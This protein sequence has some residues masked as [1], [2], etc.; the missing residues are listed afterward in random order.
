MKILSSKRLFA[1]IAGFLSVSGGVSASVFNNPLH[2]VEGLI[3]HSSTSVSSFTLEDGR[4]T[5][6]QQTN[7]SMNGMRCNL[8]D[9]QIAVKSENGQEMV[10]PLMTFSYFESQL[11]GIPTKHYI[12]RGVWKV[13]REDRNIES[14]FSVTILRQ[15]LSVNRKVQGY[16]SIED[17]AISEQIR[18]KISSN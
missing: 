18:G 5:E 16:L 14:D 4:Y 7:P 3:I 12:F 9:A 6:C 8:E 1:I 11:S 15:G 17:L 2:N 13:A 10:L